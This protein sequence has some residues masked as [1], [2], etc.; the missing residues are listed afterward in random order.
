MKI[1]PKD[2]NLLVIDDEEDLRSILSFV[3]ANAGYNVFEATNGQEGLEVAE[4]NKIHA[5]ISDIRMPKLDGVELL[6]KIREKNPKVP[7]IFLV[8][9]FADISADEA[10]KLGADGFL[11]KPYDINML[12]QDIE[13]CLLKNQEFQIS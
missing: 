4:K 12:T 13:S 5:I 6:K 3:L 9:G 8:T 1:N 7:V 2:F 11:S 10:I